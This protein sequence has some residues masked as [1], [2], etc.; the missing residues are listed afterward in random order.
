MGKK[1]KIKPAAGLEA[2]T[3]NIED[4]LLSARQRDSP[5]SKGRSTKCPVLK[6]CDRN[7]YEC[8]HLV[9]CGYN[10]ENA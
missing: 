5:P 1:D 7:N 3:R 6:I 4:R 10:G 2:T 9:K 8:P